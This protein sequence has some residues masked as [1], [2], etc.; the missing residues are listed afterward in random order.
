MQ[1]RYKVAILGD[2][3]V[4]KS[5]ICRAMIG[6]EAFKETYNPTIGMKIRICDVFDII[7][8][9]WDMSGDPQHVEIV[10]NNLTNLDATIVVYTNETRDRVYSWV[11][12]VSHLGKPI[13]CVHNKRDVEILHQDV[14][15]VSA[16]T[17][18]GIDNLK[19]ALYDKLHV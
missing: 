3:S 18:K 19:Q 17:G 14:I 12:L 1:Q 4:G 13:I 9:I 10:K 11:N 15:N 16:K 7:L 5:S 2:S 8:D 6:R